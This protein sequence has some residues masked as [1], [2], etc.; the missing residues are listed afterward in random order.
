MCSGVQPTVAWL[1]EC[2][3]ILGRYLERY[4]P[5]EIPNIFGSGHVYYMNH[6]LNK[7]YY[8]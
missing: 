6:V 4:I 7:N 2:S 3:Y 8:S 5:V 1:T